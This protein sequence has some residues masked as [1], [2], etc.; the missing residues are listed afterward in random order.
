[1]EVEETMAIQGITVVELEAVEVGMGV[2]T[3]AIVTEQALRTPMAV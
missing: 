1:M 2:T 3:T